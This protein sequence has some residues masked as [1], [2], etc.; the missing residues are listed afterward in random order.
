MID[1]LPRTGQ[2]DNQKGKI[3]VSFIK[4][5]DESFSVCSRF[6]DNFGRKRGLWY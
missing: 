6:H 1:R 5:F 3:I 4:L 2:A